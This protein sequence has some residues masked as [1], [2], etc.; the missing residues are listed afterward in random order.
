MWGTM[1]RG[2]TVLAYFDYMTAADTINSQ[3][4]EYHS[5]TDKLPF[6]LPATTKQSQM[7]LQ[8]F[9][10]RTFKISCDLFKTYLFQ[11]LH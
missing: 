1:D 11:I 10:I 8:K 7:Q 5:I 2:F 6:M 4:P 3:K 9:Y